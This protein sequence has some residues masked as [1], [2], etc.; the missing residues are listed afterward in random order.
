MNIHVEASSHSLLFYSVQFYSILFSF[1]L[2]CSVDRA[3]GS[4]RLTQRSR[5]QDNVAAG[6][7]GPVP[8]KS[9]TAEIQYPYI[10]KTGFAGSQKPQKN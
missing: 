2:F 5:R 6:K 3:A 9:G 8:Q 1:I 4:S 7:V 10:L